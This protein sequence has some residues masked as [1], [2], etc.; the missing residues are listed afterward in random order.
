MLKSDH[1]SSRLLRTVCLQNINEIH[2][3]MDNRWPSGVHLSITITYNRENIDGSSI[4][5]YTL[6]FVSV[7]FIVGIRINSV[8]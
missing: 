2:V 3:Q 6:R 4:C 8:T 1:N 5:V 7:E